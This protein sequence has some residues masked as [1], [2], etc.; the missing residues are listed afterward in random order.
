MIEFSQRKNIIY[1]YGESFWGNY[2]ENIQWTS[3][4]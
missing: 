2:V 4:K 1:Y 3:N